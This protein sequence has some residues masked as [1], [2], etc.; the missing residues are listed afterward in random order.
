ML[1]L[2]HVH[3]HKNKLVILEVLC[4]TYYSLEIPKRHEMKL[5]SLWDPEET[6]GIWPTHK[7]YPMLSNFTP[8][9]FPL[10]NPVALVSLGTR[11]AAAQLFHRCLIAAYAAFQVSPTHPAGIVGCRAGM[12]HI[13][14]LTHEPGFLHRVP[15]NCSSLKSDLP[16][17]SDK[18]L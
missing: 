14:S 17:A 13:F 16:F 3:I 10:R 1:S 4:T 5:P 9:L 7:F 2:S 18:S 8:N 6:T 12:R 15:N 11:A